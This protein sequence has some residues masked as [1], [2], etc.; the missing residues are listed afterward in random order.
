MWYSVVPTSLVCSRPL[1]WARQAAVLGAGD[2][3]PLSIRQLRPVACS[4]LEGLGS[5]EPRS[6]ALLQS[7]EKCGF[8]AL[9]ERERLADFFLY[10]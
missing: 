5:E 7:A 2:P 9:G 1:L 4:K 10:T 8:R 6:V 3:F